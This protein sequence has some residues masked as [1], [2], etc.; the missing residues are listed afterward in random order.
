M[1]RQEYSDALTRRVIAVDLYI[2]TRES[3]SANTVPIAVEYQ[4]LRCGVTALYRL[5]QAECF[6][7]SLYLRALS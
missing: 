1:I 4:C 6:C 2:P 7:G 5:G 3:H